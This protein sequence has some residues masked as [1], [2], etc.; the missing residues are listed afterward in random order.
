MDFFIRMASV[1]VDA[2][3]LITLL[4]AEEV[5]KWVGRLVPSKWMEYMP[6][7][8]MYVISGDRFRAES[9]SFSLYNISSGIFT[10][11]FAAWL[12]RWVK[13]QNSERNRVIVFWEIAK[14]PQKQRLLENSTAI[15]VSFCF[16][17]LLLTASVLARDFYG[18]ANAC[19]IIVSIFTR[20]CILHANR[21]AIDRDVSKH[22]PPKDL[23]KLIIITPDGNMITMFIPNEL[24][25]PVITRDPSS[26]P[27]QLYNAWRW[28]SWIAFGIHVTTLG[29]ATRR[30][31]L[32]Y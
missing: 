1:P 12:T 28:I 10:T 27:G 11:E 14:M 32:Y 26:Q 19:A 5:N 31:D 13:C 22:G 24:I 25:I 4:G 17:G 21:T 30:P 20:A 8:A 23:Q 6:L 15:S 29:M 2:L 7:L 18:A 16:T 9:P 3:G